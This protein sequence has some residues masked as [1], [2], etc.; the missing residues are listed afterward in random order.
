MFRRVRESVSLF[1][2]FVECC[3]ST[4][5]TAPADGRVRGAKSQPFTVGVG[6]RQGC[7]LSPLLYMNWIES[8]LSRRGRHCWKICRIN[9]LLFADDLVLLASSQQVFQHAL[10]RFATCNQTGVKISTNT[11]RGTSSLQKPKTVHAASKPHYSAAGEE[12]QVPWGSIHERRKAEQ[13][14]WYTNC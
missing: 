8:Q 11:D 13:R 5:L 9:R 4:V 7:V 12:V 6:L 3:G 2:S 1:K 10:D 14:D